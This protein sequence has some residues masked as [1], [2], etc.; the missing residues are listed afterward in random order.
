MGLGYA[1]FGDHAASN[2]MVNYAQTD[3]LAIVGRLATGSSILFGFPL[4][5]LGLKAKAK[6]FYEQ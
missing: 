3:G 2:V 4:A 5:M 1:T 6:N